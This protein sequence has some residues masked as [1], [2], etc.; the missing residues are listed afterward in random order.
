VNTYPI[1]LTLNGEKVSLEVPADR[2]L[3]QL[4]SE[5]LHQHSVKSGCYIGEC[6]LCTVI[7][8]GRPVNSCLVLAVE[9]DGA[10]IE[11]AECETREPG[12][13]SDLQ[14]AFVD[15]GAIQCGFCTPG[16]LNSARALLERNPRP[17]REE[18]VEALAGNYCRCTGY[19]PI[20]R[21]VEA[22]AR[23]G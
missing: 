13:L 21:A 1:T 16:M 11:T 2:T 10:V 17:S 7:V 3:H 4:L 14:Q 6:G 18:I 9:A 19:E 22:V 15:F 20:L 8:N 5:D 12:V 23:G